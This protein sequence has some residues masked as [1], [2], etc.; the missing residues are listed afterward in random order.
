MADPRLDR[1]KDLVL[2]RS[3]AER[4]PLSADVLDEL[5]SH[6]ADV[7]EADRERG[8][9]DADAAASARAVL[10][11]ASFDELAGTS[12][13]AAVPSSLVDR[14]RPGR[15]R[16]WTDAWFDV[17]YALRAMRRSASFS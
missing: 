1:W 6:L 7:Y 4:Q 17:R 11:R 12:R 9:S 15:G 8:R 16:L 3:R 14:A 5:A 13:V 10:Q 2:A